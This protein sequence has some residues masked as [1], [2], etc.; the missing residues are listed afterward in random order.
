MAEPA[1]RPQSTDLILDAT[2]RLLGRYGFRKMT[3]DDIA[4]EA[5]VARRTIYLHFGSKEEVALASIDRVVDGVLAA[6]RA[7]AA[8]RRRVDT[9]LRDMLVTRV[10][11][12][13][14]RVAAYHE[15]LE[16]LFADLRPTYLA[17]RERYFAAE[18]QVFAD[19]LAEGQRVRAL[20]TDDPL[21][22]AHDLLL[23]TNSL[24]PYSLSPRELGDRD[25]VEQRC[26]RLARL[27]LDGVRRRPA[28]RPSRSTGKETA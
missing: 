25:A 2:E 22:T 28:A 8:E 9:R 16:T 21:T 14:D 1:L 11:F 26:Q 12:R 4:A 23:A 18:A 24:I 20:A 13:F 6:L 5:G 3:M 27:L 15:G 10:M 17:R 19:V 7:I